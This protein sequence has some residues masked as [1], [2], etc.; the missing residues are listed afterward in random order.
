MFKK[1]K[2]GYPG[3]LAGDII[4]YDWLSGYN[5]GSI[6]IDNKIELIAKKR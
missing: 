6:K 2:K 4:M 1:I 3:L 5:L